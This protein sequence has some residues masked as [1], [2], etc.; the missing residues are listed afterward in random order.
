VVP[1]LDIRDLALV[2]EV[3]GAGSVSRAAA[4]LHLTQSALSHRLRAAESRLGT[5]L[6]L[7]VGKKMVP[8]P[9]GERV[10]DVARRVLD[11]LERTETDVRALG[12]D[13]GGLLRLSTQ[14]YTGYHWLP[15]LLGTFQERYPLVD[16]QIAVDATYRPVEAL[17]AGEIDLAVLTRA[18]KDNRLT[19]RPLFQDELFAIVAPTHPFAKRQFVEAPDFAAE[20]LITYMIDRR[21]SLLFRE[22]LDP[23]AVTPARISRVPLT[24]AILEMV[25]AGLGVAVLE[26]WAVAPALDSGAVSA[27]RI[28]RRG[29][30]RQWSVATLRGAG[31]PQWRTDFIDLLRTFAPAPPRTSRPRRVS[32]R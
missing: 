9:A 30:I 6:F 4:K 25:K 13:R 5:A 3:T 11:D 23:A 21:E 16:V 31:E 8:T 20:H 24:E 17:L 7:R 22:I 32:A 2:R 29:I 27:V 14:C 26:R 1:T 10:L 18:A 19:L 12:H 15:A 28:T